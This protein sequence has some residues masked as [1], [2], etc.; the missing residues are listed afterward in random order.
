MLLFALLACTE[1]PPSHGEADPPAVEL[2]PLV[3]RDGVVIVDL[4]PPDGGAP[5]RLTGR[6][7][8]PLEVHVPPGRWGVHAWLDLDGDAAWDGIWAEGEPA[9]RFGVQLPRGPLDVPL[10]AGVPAPRLADHP[11]WVALHDLAWSLLAE[12]VAAGTPANGFAARYLDEGASPQISQWDSVFMTLFAR[13]GADAFPVMETLDNFY[14]VQRPDGYIGRVLDEDDGAMASPVDPSDPMINPPLFGWSERSWVALT[15]DTSRLRRVVPALDA[16]HGWLDA[17]VR[18]GVG[19]YYTSLLGSGMDNAPREAAYDGWVDI[20]AQQALGRAELAALADLAGL[21]GAP[22][23]AEHARIC[24]DVHDRMFA[25]GWF[26]DLGPDGAPLPDKTLAGV[27]PLLAGCADPGQAADAARWLADPA[28]FWRP[29]VFPSTSADSPA[30]EPDGHAWR[31]GVWG[32]T[33]Y[34]TLR[35]LRHLGYGALA[36][37]AADNHLLNLAAVADRFTPGPGELAPDAPGDGLGALWELYAPDA[38]RPGT[39]G[40]GTFLGRDDA[41]GGSGLGP[42]A[43]LYED[44]LGLTPDALTDTLTLRVRRRDAHGI[45]GYRVG[46]Q[47][48]DLDVAAR[49]PGGPLEVT[50]TTSDAFTLRVE[51]ADATGWSAVV[52]VPKGRSTYRFTPNAPVPWVPAGPHAGFAV[53]GNGRM[54][55]VVGEG[56]GPGISHLYR[57]D[58]GLDLVERG[59]TR[60]IADGAELL[61]ARTGMGPFFAAAAEV[62]LPGGG[63][64]SWRSF[65]GADDALVVQGE[66]VGGEGGAEVTVLPWLTLREAPDMDGVVQRGPVRREGDALVATWSDGSAFTLRSAPAAAALGAGDLRLDP[67]APAGGLSDSVT[68]GRTLALALPLSAGPREVVPFRWALGDADAALARSDAQADAARLHAPFDLTPRCGE[69]C[70]VAAANLAA[71]AASRLGGDVPA[72][73]TGQFVTNGAPQ[74]YPRDAMMVARAL[75]AVGEDAPARVILQS[76]LGRP[77]PAPGEWYARYDA[78]GRAVDAGSGAAFDEPEWDSNAYAALL[79]LALGPETWSADEQQA[80]LLALDLLVDRQDADGLWTEGGIVEWTGRLPGTAMVA[81]AGLDAGAGLAESWGEPARA[82]RYLAAAGRVRGGLVELYHADRDL[83]GDER[84]GAL[85]LDTSLFFGPALGFPASP[86]LTRTYSSVR[87]RHTLL[88]GGV[89]YF[90]GNDY[91]DD[92]FFFTTAG[93]LQYGVTLG[94]E[95]GVTEALQWMMASTNR[96]GLAPE[97]IYDSGD[98]AAPAS[99]LSWCAAELALSVLAAAPAPALDGEVS[100]G[101]H[102]GQGLVDHDGLPDLPGDP[103]ALYAH[104]DGG[105]LV[106][107]LRTAGAAPGAV[108][109][110]LSGADG[111]GPIPGPSFLTPPELT[112]GARAV[113]DLDACADCAVAWGPLGVEAKIPLAPRGLT[114]PLQVV[115]EADG[116]LLPAR[117]ALRTDGED[118][119]LLL[120]FQVE[121]AP[122]GEDVH[123]SGDLAELGAWAGDAIPLHDDGTRGDELAGDGVWTTTV[124]VP[125]G[126]WIAW[127]HMT[128]RTGDGSWAG[129]EM[130]GDNRAVP[131]GDPD[132]NGRAVIASRFGVVG[133]VVVDP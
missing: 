29:H 12:R 102:R 104:V 65:I 114:A 14:G 112:P 66:L 7:G 52:A 37:A 77:G 82:A 100:P 72:D 76:W 130:A 75:H 39:R 123:L 113:V 23:R 88:G 111:Q 70:Q 34:A 18:T 21:D 96:Y 67:G 105:E 2:R 90:E 5:V 25:D 53:L 32:P 92:L 45:S 38:R 1:P 59:G 109:L 132:G 36:S 120:S 6:V 81:W 98:G 116:D 64:V 131:I 17:H 83:L 97:R 110:W 106:V 55:A 50:V 133:Q 26:R 24:A 48:V 69:P 79:A 78:R 42:I 20:T 31:G 101:E 46:E 108:R 89:R 87:A 95:A 16:Y 73:L 103:V 126:G 125:R 41:V 56:A 8:E 74:L 47:L 22:S 80:I 49:V 71:A 63:R 118:G 13:Y 44:V 43:V 10:R 119:W 127:K 35:A 61:P 60:V 68:V 86:M 129:V 27:W 93:V 122:A 115:A 84:G 121:G 85:A 19:L 62:P 124:R 58:F 9:A 91:G 28:A 3:D 51:D 128:G 30:F 11:E 4:L 94:D 117:G 54:T 107:G 40:D 57:G 33:S 99:P 15:G